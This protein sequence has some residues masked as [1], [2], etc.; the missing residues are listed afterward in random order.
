VARVKKAE[1][2]RLLAPLIDTQTLKE[3]NATRRTPKSFH[4]SSIEN[5]GRQQFYGMKGVLPDPSV[6]DPNWKRDAA[7]GNAIHDQYQGILLRSGIVLP[8]D[9]FLD[10]A[11]WRRADYPVWQQKDLPKHALEIPLPPNQYRIGGRIDAVV[12]V[13]GIVYI[14]DIKTLKTKAFNEMVPSNYKFKK[15]MAQLSVYGY[16][17]GI[18]NLGVCG[19]CRDDSLMREWLVKYDEEWCVKQFARITELKRMLDQNILPPREPSWGGC[20]FCPFASVCATDD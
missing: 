2:V 12:R 14:F 9:E 20:N 6:S 10:L 4:A 8:T 19:I 16:L 18:H 11:K 3:E 5:C 15:F 7:A 1:E 13:E 17:S